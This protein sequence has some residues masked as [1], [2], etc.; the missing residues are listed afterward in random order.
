MLI[1]LCVWQ[2]QLNVCSVSISVVM[3]SICKFFDEDAVYKINKKKFVDVGLVLENSEYLSSDEDDPEYREWGERM[4]KGHIRVA[5]H[6]NGA[7][8]VLPEKKVTFPFLSLYFHALQEPNSGTAPYLSL[9]CII[10]R[11]PVL[12]LRSPA[13]L[14]YSHH[15]ELI[16]MLNIFP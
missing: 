12:L 7:E 13:F 8:E 6:P 5:W 2:L 9:L 14:F 4:K 3:A 11:L 15:K 16:F 10:I 1:V